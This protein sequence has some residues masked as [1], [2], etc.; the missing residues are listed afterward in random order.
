VVPIGGDQA[1]YVLKRKI[2]DYFEKNGIDYFDLGNYDMEV[3]AY[4][5]FVD[6]LYNFMRKYKC[7]KGVLLCGSG[8]GASI[9]M[10]KYPGIRCGRCDCVTAVELGRRENDM[11]VLSM[12]GRIVGPELAVDMVEVFLNTAFDPA[13]ASNLEMIRQFDLDLYKTEHVDLF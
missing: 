2:I 12:G 11:N 9:V 3:T 7:P 8:L 10:N 6:K 5:I 13:F 1:S 4:Y